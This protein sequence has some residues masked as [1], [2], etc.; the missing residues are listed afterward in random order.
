MKRFLTLKTLRNYFYLLGFAAAMPFGWVDSV[1][2]AGPPEIVAKS[3]ILLDLNSGRILYERNADEK[4]PAASTQ[5]LLTALLVLENG[6]L[7]A[8]VRVRATDTQVEPTVVGISPG[9]TY[10]RRQLLTALLVRSG[11]DVAKC[12][13]RDHSGSSER[14]ARAMNAKAL[15]LGMTRSHF[16]NPSGLPAKEQY[17]TARDI[18]RLAIE[19]RRYRFVRE[20]VRLRSVRFDFPNGKHRV[21][22]NTNKLLGRDPIV[23]GMKTGYTKS[24]G[25]CLVSTASYNGRAVLAVV[26]GSP[27]PAWDQSQALL[28]WGL[29]RG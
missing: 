19:A 29:T 1:S 4:R 10:T 6:N 20:T 7:D 26:L 17:S 13:A 22:T 5:K 11:N 18:A 25:Y 23:D 3:A 2:A 24:S 27:V 8:R 21:L 15:Q 14:F 28:R 12:L 16:V 9:H